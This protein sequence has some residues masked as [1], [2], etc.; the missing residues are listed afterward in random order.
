MPKEVLLMKKYA[1]WK[2]NLPVHDIRTLD[3]CYFDDERPVGNDHRSRCRMR[4][5]N[6]V[7][8]GKGRGWEWGGLARDVGHENV[9]WTML[10]CADITLSPNCS[11]IASS[12]ANYLL[13]YIISCLIL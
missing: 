5:A 10:S 2:Y 9:N 8:K 6:E 13:K 3:F 4:R 7:G 1:Q 11:I 12:L